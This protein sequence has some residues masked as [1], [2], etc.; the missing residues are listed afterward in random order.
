[1][2]TISLFVVVFIIATVAFMSRVAAGA[3]PLHQLAASH[4]IISNLVHAL[5]D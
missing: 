5:E 3:H 2:I 4:G 1:M